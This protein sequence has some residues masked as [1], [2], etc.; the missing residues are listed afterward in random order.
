MKV[1]A[2]LFRIV[3]DGVL[4]YIVQAPERYA[5]DVR[6]EMDRNLQ[7]VNLLT[8]LGSTIS[9]I[10]AAFIIFTTLSM[11]VTERQRTLAMLRAISLA[12]QEPEWPSGIAVRT[13]EPKDAH[14]VHALLDEAYR[15]WDGTYVPLK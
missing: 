15:G 13:F 14:A 11:G 12:E 9:I 7:G 5:G 4:K 10:V 3:N 1:G 2:P 6:K 8:Y